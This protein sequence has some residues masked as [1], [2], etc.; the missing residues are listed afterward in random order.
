MSG[1]VPT[2][3]YSRLPIIDWYKFRVRVMLMPSPFCSVTLGSAGVD[4]GL[5][6]LSWYFFKDVLNVLLLMQFK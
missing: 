4:T 6:S 3:A 1:L 5:T 2:A